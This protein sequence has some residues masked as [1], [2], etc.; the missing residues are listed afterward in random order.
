MSDRVL[1][2]EFDG[3]T[4][5]I[6][7]GPDLETA[8]RYMGYAMQGQPGCICMTNADKSRMM[9]A[10]GGPDFENQEMTED[11]ALVHL[12]CLWMIFVHG[13]RVRKT[14]EV[15]HVDDI[16][17]NGGSWWNRLCGRFCQEEVTL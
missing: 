11:L 4:T 13:C 5:Y 17:S 8:Q 7:E 12:V 10:Y 6:A 2:Q 9:V 3:G 14:K 1:I 15:H 16:V